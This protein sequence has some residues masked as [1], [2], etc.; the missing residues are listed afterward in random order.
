V[1]PPSGQLL[2]T[3]ELLSDKAIVPSRLLDL[4]LSTALSVS[5]LRSPPSYSPRLL[6]AILKRVASH[7]LVSLEM[8]QSEADEVIS[9][10]E[11][12]QSASTDREIDKFDALELME[13]IQHSLL[14]ELSPYL[15][16]SLLLQGTSIS[17]LRASSSSVQLG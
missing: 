2:S 14:E 6:S 4:S 3:P 15:R 17:P 16:A 13:R 5:C 9:L 8:S 7:G 12:L 10:L 1:N 11:E